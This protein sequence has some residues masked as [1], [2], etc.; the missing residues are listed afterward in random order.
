MLKLYL[1]PRAIE[2][3][4]DIYEYTL[5][6]WGLTQADKYQD[7]LYYSMNTILHS[8]QIGTKYPYKKGNYRKL[9]S[10]KHIVFYRIEDQKC[11]IIRILHEKMDFE[12]NL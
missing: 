4:E 5:I 7:L 6:T 11:V 1:S 10:N 8:P 9:N 12:S 2:D 3:L